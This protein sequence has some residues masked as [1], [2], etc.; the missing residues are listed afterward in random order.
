MTASI[1]KYSTLL[2][3]ALSVLLLYPGSADAHCDSMGGP[4]VKSAEKALETGNVNLV[5]IWVTESQEAE[6]RESFHNTMKVRSI[7]ED[8][9]KLADRYFFETLVR[10]HR[11]AEGAPY[12][13]LKRANTDFGPAIP[14]AEKALE[15]GS[16]KE[17]RDLL[18]QSI[19]KGLHH[20]YDSTAELKDFDPNDIQAGR[21]YVN[22]YVQFMHYVNPVYRAATADVTHGMGEHDH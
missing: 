16:L 9:R 22:A 11:E 6:I 8:T 7:N 12:T 17:V 4:V 3:L 15:T 14:A 5:L 2:S 19:E 21:A 18:V 20:Y 10:L 13:G 1:I